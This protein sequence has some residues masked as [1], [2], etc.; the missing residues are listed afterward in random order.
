MENEFVVSAI[1]DNISRNGLIEYGIYMDKGIFGKDRELVERFY[2]NDFGKGDYVLRRETVGILRQRA[3][4]FAHMRGVKKIGA[5][6]SVL[7][8][9]A[10]E[11]LLVWKGEKKE[12]EKEE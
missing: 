4:V 12:G 5:V 11:R 2:A 9:E 1:I 10:K 8:D 3:I 7:L 6:D